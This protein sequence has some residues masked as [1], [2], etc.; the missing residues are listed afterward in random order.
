[1]GIIK[2]KLKQGDETVTREEWRWVKDYEDLYKIS[3][4]GRIKSMV[5][6]EKILKPWKQ[7][8]GHLK[9]TLYKNGSAKKHQL[10]RLIAEAF[11]PNHYNKP[12]INHIDCNPSNNYVDNL[13]WVTQQENIRHS[14][15]MGRHY[16]P[17]GTKINEEL[18]FD[19]KKRLSNGERII[20]ISKDSNLPY[21]IIK[22]I[23]RNK[24][25]RSVEVEK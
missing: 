16:L 12:C 14:V 19:I 23:K 1:M 21:H 25:W 2:K 9:V 10:H 20:T 24:T 15:K 22:D 8:Q 6:N 17:S 4:H 3:N 7:S 13:E 11:I 5:K 18:A